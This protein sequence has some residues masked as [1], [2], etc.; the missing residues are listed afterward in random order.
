MDKLTKT[1]I[2]KLKDIA[3]AVEDMIDFDTSNALNLIQIFK[4]LNL[5]QLDF[6]TNTTV[7]D[8][9][10]LSVAGQNKAKLEIS[11]LPNDIQNLMVLVGIQNQLDTIDYSINYLEKEARFEALAIIFQAIEPYASIIN[12]TQR[13]ELNSNGTFAR[14]LVLDK[15]FAQMLKD[16]IFSAYVENPEIVFPIKNEH[17]RN[18]VVS[19]ISE[20]FDE[21]ECSYSNFWLGN[22]VDKLNQYFNNLVDKD[23]ASKSDIIHQSD[24]LY[25]ESIDKLYQSTSQFTIFT[26]NN[27]STTKRNGIFNFSRIHEINFTFE[28]PVPDGLNK[29]EFYTVLWMKNLISKYEE[30]MPNSE[31]I[32]DLAQLIYLQTKER[33]A[34]KNVVNNETKTKLTELSD[35]MASFLKTYNPQVGQSTINKKSITYK[36]FREFIDAIETNV[37][38]SQKVVDWLVE[39]TNYSPTTTQSFNDDNEFLKRLLSDLNVA[40]SLSFVENKDEKKHLINKIC[41]SHTKVNITNIYKIN[42]QKSNSDYKKDENVEIKHKTLVHGTSNASILTILRDGLL[43]R[44]EIKNDAFNTETGLG[45]GDGIYF[46]QCHQ[47]GKSLNYTSENNG[48]RYLFV[49][50]V[51]YSKQKEVSHFGYYDSDDS[52]DL[53]Y[54]KAV[55]SY[56]RDELVSRTSKQI[57]L[58]YLLEIHE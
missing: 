40:S 32:S 28:Q 33:L 31:L 36:D 9:S 51:A 10:N 6:I 38:I 17:L 43:T 25:N 27:K 30:N 5:K 39:N 18:A 19:L 1:D 14:P 58:K 12:K 57:E 15:P 35:A 21:K 45:L 47:A 50:D 53:L 7:F 8:E 56:D 34:N 41:D 13:F 55:G 3:H 11:K 24:M 23:M 52:W 20:S 48:I 26:L 29:K 37:Q 16:Q 42:N 49:A 2:K 22:I 54:A 4:R 46:A 44:S